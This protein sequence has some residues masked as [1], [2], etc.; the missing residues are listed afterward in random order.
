MDTLPCM[1]PLS[2]LVFTILF[3]G[4]WRVSPITLFCWRHTEPWSIHHHY[5]TYAFFIPLQKP[6]NT[7]RYIFG[8]LLKLSLRSVTI[9]TPSPSSFIL[10]PLANIISNKDSSTNLTFL[11]N[12]QAASAPP[13]WFPIPCISSNPSI[14]PPPHIH[15]KVK[16]NC[17]TQ[18]NSYGL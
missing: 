4:P 9:A 3:H 15:I 14:P 12:P 16:L 5:S 10:F 1:K 8:I 11:N 6:N 2:P 13:S 18:F 17:K 7:K